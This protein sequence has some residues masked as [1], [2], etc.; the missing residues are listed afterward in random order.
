VLCPEKR[1]FRGPGQIG[2]QGGKTK[3]VKIRVW[4]DAFHKHAGGGEHWYRARK[5]EKSLKRKRKKECK[6]SDFHFRKKD[7]HV[8]KIVEKRGS[9]A[10]IGRG[11]GERYDGGT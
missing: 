1:K 11:K 7:W 4:G 3:G 6:K 2:C 10:P 9:S 8:S 5:D